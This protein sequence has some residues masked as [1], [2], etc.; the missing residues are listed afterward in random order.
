MATVAEQLTSLANTKTAIKDAIVAKGVTVADTDTFRSYA[1]KIGQISGGGGGAPATKYG[2][3]ID[4]LL[5]DV[6]ENGMLQKPT[7]TGVLDLTGVAKVGVSGLAYVFDNDNNVRGVLANDVVFV[8]I[9][10]FSH[11]FAGCSSLDTM[12][13]NGLESITAQLAFSYIAQSSISTKLVPHFNKLKSIAAANVFYYGFS[14]IVIVPDKTFPS[15]EHV[16]GVGVFS[17]FMAY[18]E[19]EPICFSKIKTIAGASVSFSAT[20]GAIYVKN[21]I[22]NLPRVSEITD[23]VWYIP[24]SYPGEIH[25]AAANQ[26]AIEACAGY[27]KKWGFVAATIYFDLILTIVVN[28]ITYSREYTIDGY[29]SWKDTDDNIVYTDATAEPAV[30][31][32]VYSDAGVTQVGTVTEVA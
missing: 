21:T 32:V 11:T 9:S 24:S 17:N 22:W 28:G 14:S 23:Y 3:S 18:K 16:S 2:I 27:D 7:W 12:E 31:T 19:G 13:F 26:A 4:N 6:D 20:F 5:G 29:T 30:D 10:A 25:F 1:D 8:N 15:L